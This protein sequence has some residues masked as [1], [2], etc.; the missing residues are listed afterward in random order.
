MFKKHLMYNDRQVILLTFIALRR[1]T[2]Q[3]LIRHKKSCTI[4]YRAKQNKTKTK[5][6]VKI[7]LEYDLQLI[8][9]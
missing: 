9:C 7:K 4:K 2:A 6:E 1:F 8:F 5:I 3:Q